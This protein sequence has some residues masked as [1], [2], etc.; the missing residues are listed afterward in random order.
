V[1]LILSREE[2]FETVRARHPM[3][4]RVKTG[5]RRDGTLV[6]REVEILL[7]GGA[8]ADDSP[9]VLGYAC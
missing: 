5:A 2:D 1:K 7:D 3:K 6:A 4:V 9:G 8:F